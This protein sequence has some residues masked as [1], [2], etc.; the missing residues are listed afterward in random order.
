MILKVLS[1][2]TQLAGSQAPS[3]EM[4]TASFDNARTPAHATISDETLFASFEGAAHKR[5]VTVSTLLSLI[6]P[7]RGVPTT[8]SLDRH[9][10]DDLWRYD[11]RQKKFLDSFAL[12][13]STSRVGGETASAVC[14][15]QPLG[16]HPSGNILRIARNLGVPS[17]LVDKFQEILDDLTAVALRGA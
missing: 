8:H 10:H 7:V 9:P 1:T 17:D 13:C 14:L 11:Q 16:G 6:D 3:P 15:E 12:I 2:Q 5:F 4:D